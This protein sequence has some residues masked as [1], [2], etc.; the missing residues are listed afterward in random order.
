M[1]VEVAIVA[2]DLTGALDVAGP[3]AARGQRTVVAVDERA[4]APGRFGAA[5][6]VSINATSR[7]LP[8]ARAAALVEDVVARLCP[9]GAPILIKKIDSTLRGNVAA[10]TLAMLKASG[11]RC[12]I[13]APAF[14][15]QGR[16]MIDA[17]VHVRGEP[18]PATPFARDALSPPPLAPLDAVFRA[19][20]PEARVARVA[21][22]GRIDTGGGDGGLVVLVVDSTTDADLE[23]CVRGLQGRLHECVLVGSA[24]IA[25]AVARVCM[26]P[27]PP[28]GQPRLAGDILIA[29]GSRAEQSAA[30]VATLAGQP[31][32]TLFS[33][34]NGRVDGA[35][36]LADDAPIQVLKA[37]PD[38]QGR[39]GD[40]EAVARSLAAGVVERV[41]ARQVDALLATGGD[42]AIAILHALSCAMLEV[43]GDLVPGI[44]YSRLEVEGRPL[45]L[46][47]KAGGFGTA[48]TLV[49]V[50]RRLRRGPE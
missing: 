13:V 45:L 47:T 20:A 32:V 2:D 30:Q 12:A 7:H 17:M 10:E 24:G 40:A 28:R 18:L 42:T 29:V 14:P 8:A 37:T 34:P 44:P 4:C 25:A 38:A 39:E 9:A 22:D 43:M 16:T 26:P 23:H 6:V 21:A 35:A 49:Q 36:M 33:A 31:G 19:A 5:D 3:F 48:D 46:L 41:R 27:A 1:A 50:V 11:R 15:A